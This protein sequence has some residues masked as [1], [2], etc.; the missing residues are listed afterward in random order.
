MERVRHRLRTRRYSRRTEQ[1]YCAWIRR[2]IIHH[3]RR[4][5]SLLGEADVADF[6]THL[7]VHER[8]AAPTQ[9]QALQAIL[10]LYRHVLFKPVG[11]VGSFSRAK[12]PRRLPVVLTALEVRSILT[13]MRGTTRLCAILMYGSGLRVSE[14]LALRVKDLDFERA[15]I[16]VRGG[17]GDKDRRV[18]LPRTVVPALREHLAT[19]KAQFS[20]DLAR[21]YAGAPLPNA[22]SR[23]LSDA[24]RDWRWQWVF[25][26]ARL[27]RETGTGL[28]RR[29]HLHPTAVQRAFAAAV[30]ASGTTKRATCHALRHSF[31]THLLEHGTD[32]RVIQELLGHTEVRTTM[33]Y[34]HALN[35]GGG[36]VR[37][38]ADQL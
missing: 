21:A 31:A 9:N 10:F 12:S 5:P 28:I 25:P 27:Y 1:A 6:L 3:D 18:P 19:A 11:F 30:R 26:S 37:S 29:H 36:V 13:K 15:E 20:R 38:P 14:C 2:F 8:V 17:K 7:A 4:H 23:K 33:L 35:R 32:I 16:A 34:T 22:L 24:G